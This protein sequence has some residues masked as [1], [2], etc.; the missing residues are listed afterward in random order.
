MNV[1]IFFML[2]NCPSEGVYSGHHAILIAKNL[3]VGSEG[4]LNCLDPMKMKL[5][6]VNGIIGVSLL[7]S[8]FY[9]FLRKECILLYPVST[10]AWG[11]VRCVI[12][13]TGVDAGA[14]P[15]SPGGRLKAF[16]MVGIFQYSS[17]R[18][19]T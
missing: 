2:L 12:S 3:N 9:R 8:E 11:M 6:R 14:V 1:K 17:V 19:S 13:L 4:L 15:P 5:S 10:S 7:E 18:R 16:V